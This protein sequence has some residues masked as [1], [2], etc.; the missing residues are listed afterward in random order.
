MKK[1]VLILLLIILIAAGAVLLKKRKQSMTK[2]PLA[3][4]MTYT[5]KIVEPETR[6]VSQTATFL[7]KLE[8]ANSAA[9]SAKLSG[10]IKTLLVRE[11]QK[12]DQGELLVRIDDQEIQTAIKALQAQLLFAE[13]QRNYSKNQYQRNL[14]LFEVGGLAQEKL[15]DSELV[16]SSAAAT[17]E[18]LKQKI[19]SLKNEL[20][21]LA[22]KAPFAGIVGTI[23]LRQGDLAA[24]NRPILSLNSRPQKLTFSFTPAKD[25]ICSGQEVRLN[26]VKTGEITNLYNDATNGLAV[27]EV[28]LNKLLE[29]PN[30]S[31]LTIEVVSKT[32]SGCAVPISALLHRKAGTSVMLYQ[33]DHFREKPIIVLAQGKEFALIDPPVSH[34]VAVAAEAKLSLLPTYGKVRIIPGDK[35][36]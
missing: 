31:Y 16:L 1:I 7:A 6:T 23:F 34:P 11:S 29:R 9:I 25:E 5:V 26:H 4:P 8:S 12:V 21:Y 28:V 30:G 10:R 3:T 13:K 22:I 36:E 18:D 33:E 24:P 14:A 20:D 17:V 27:A 19:S 2:A 35:N 15:E 32:A